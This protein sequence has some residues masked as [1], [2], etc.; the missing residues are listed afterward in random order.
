MIFNFIKYNKSIWYF[1]LKP[2]TDFCYFPTLQQIEKQGFKLDID[3]NF[4]SIEAQNRDLAYRA[5]HSG[6]INKNQ[7]KVCKQRR[8]YY[9][10]N[11]MSNY[12]CF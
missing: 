1:N 8:R 2:K 7:E 11:R 12:R 4:K 6:F 10:K 3:A 9:E 5:F